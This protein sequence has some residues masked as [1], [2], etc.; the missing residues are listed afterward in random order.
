MLI[1]NHA[2]L[3][4]TP[5]SSACRNR[6]AER[7]VCCFGTTSRGANC[8]AD[9]TTCRPACF[10][11]CRTNRFACAAGDPHGCSRGRASRTNSR[12]SRTNTGAYRRAI[13]RALRHVA[14]TPTERAEHRTPHA[15]AA[16]FL[17]GR[18]LGAAALRWARNEAGSA[19]WHNLVSRSV[20]GRMH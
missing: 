8:P 4:F 19:V 12:A 18:F 10:C 14:G 6:A 11:G 5:L 16:G 13:N 7:V 3:R 1:S 20:F 17:L 9:E 15:N 2:R